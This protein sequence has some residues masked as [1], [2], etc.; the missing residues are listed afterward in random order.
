[1]ALIKCKNCGHQISDKAT[2]C[3]ICGGE[4]ILMSINNIEETISNESPKNIDY[5][6]ENLEVGSPIEETT[7][8]TNNE[9]VTKESSPTETRISWNKIGIGVIAICCIILCCVIFIPHIGDDDSNQEMSNTIAEQTVIDDNKVAESKSNAD[10]VSAKEKTLN[11]K[12]ANTIQEYDSFD[13]FQYGFAKVYKGRN[14]GCIDTKG[15][16]IV[17]CEFS[18]INILNNNLI[19]AE[20]STQSLILNGKGKPIY[21]SSDVK[22][23]YNDNIII[24]KAGGKYG[25]LSFEGEEILPCEYDKIIDS[26]QEEFDPHYMLLLEKDG[27][28][29]CANRYGKIILPCEY[30]YNNW[31]APS[32]KQINLLVDE[33]S[34]VSVNGKIYH[35]NEGTES[36]NEDTNKQ[37]DIIKYYNAEI[38]KWGLKDAN[39]DVIL[40]PKYHFIGNFSDGYAYVHIDD[41]YGY[42]NTK[43][44]EIIPLEYDEADDFYNGTTWV[45]VNGKWGMIDTQRNVKFPFICDDLY[46]SDDSSGN[47]NGYKLIMTNGRQGIVNPEGKEITNL[48]YDRICAPAG[49][50][51]VYID[52]NKGP[53]IVQMGDKYGAINA[54]GEEIVPCKYNSMENFSDGLAKVSIT[55]NGT[56]IYGYVDM[57]GTDA[58]GRAPQNTYGDAERTTNYRKSNSSNDYDWIQG[59][60]RYVMQ[61]YGV[62]MEMRVGISGDIIV[63]MMNRE[64]YYQGTYNIKDNRLEYNRSGGAVD[65]LIIDTINQRLMVDDGKPMQRF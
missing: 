47:P 13:S 50:G 41:K 29:G 4:I 23:S 27:K 37:G 26:S 32:N 17:P 8:I 22:L 9:E 63:V 24:V 53:I 15:N 36:A 60:W 28:Y 12:L 58:F 62:N 45:R 20:S 18:K 19:L 6:V 35:E 2:K 34:S 65:Y 33:Y 48:K 46:D 57:S 42:I 61:A 54:S 16:E 49:D 64:M 5:E 44:E 30:Y 52:F 3:P 39:D 55:E 31:D 38:G 56:Q 1:M 43:G 7:T 59:N 10:N 25:I 21:S 40:S 51:C 14:I 11:D